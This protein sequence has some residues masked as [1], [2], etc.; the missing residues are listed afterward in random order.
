ME[1]MLENTS[2]QTIDIS[3][4]QTKARNGCI[5]N[6]VNSGLVS[7]YSFKLGCNFMY[8]NTKKVRF[9]LRKSSYFLFV[10]LTQKMIFVYDEI[11]AF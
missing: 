8:Q 9:G 2:Y 10:L 6:R 4:L 7:I 1:I 11:L 3:G 5:K